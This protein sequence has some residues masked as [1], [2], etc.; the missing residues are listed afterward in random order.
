M[1]RSV[2]GIIDIVDNHRVGASEKPL[3]FVLPSPSLG[4]EVTIGWIRAPVLPHIQAASTVFSV[5]DDTV[6]FIA[7][8]DDFE[9]R[10]AA[11]AG[12]CAQWR[13]SGLFSD[14]IGPKKWRDELYSVYY[15][16]FQ[17]SAQGGKEVAFVM[18]RTCC[19]LFGLV[20]Y[21]VHMSMYTE[22]E[23]GMRL[24]IPTRAKTKQTWGGYL[25]NTVAGGI[26]HG[27]SPT[28]A[29]IKECME[30]ASLPEDFVRKHLKAVGVVSY[31]YQTKEGWLQPEVQYTYDL[32]VPSGVDTPAPQPLD[33][34]V[35][36]FALL[37][38]DEAMEKMHQGLFKP[39]CALVLVDFLIRHGIITA[40][41]EPNY[42]DIITRTHGRWGMS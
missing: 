8:L 4:S 21:G 24:W 28:E 32:R 41:S 5:S 16:P 25:D 18:E 17:R 3:R 38:V 9:R 10:S 34:E 33:G 27:M 13:D 29:L 6:R 36:S 2:Q 1:T 23:S 20:T 11:V 37:S 39:N 19:S 26:P 42:L 30:E 35:E 15:D 14:T 31:F 12:L 22:D 40:E 7:S